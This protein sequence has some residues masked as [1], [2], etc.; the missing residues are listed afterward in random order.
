MLVAGPAAADLL[1]ACFGTTWTADGSCTVAPGETVVYY[2]RGADGGRGGDGGQG[3]TGGLGWTGKATSPGGAGRVGGFGAAPGAGA[4]IIGTFTNATSA[5]IVLDLVVGEA[6]R[7]GQPGAIGAAGDDAPEDPLGFPGFTGG[8]GGTGG[9]GST[10]GSSSIAVAGTP[11]VIAGGGT[12]GTGGTGG[13]GG[14]GGGA[15]GSTG[16]S[17]APGNPGVSGTSGES[18]SLLPA[19]ALFSVTPGPARIVFPVDA[20]PDDPRR[21]STVAGGLPWLRS[22]GRAASDDCP[23]GWGASWQAWAQSVTGGWVC[24]RTLPATG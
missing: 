22:V 12:G 15:D 9:A 1:P 2:V 16:I 11:F 20:G 13:Q 14:Q 21:R 6:A 8:T 17:G 10:G 23:E 3:G 4:L 5:G 24:T 18:T 19:G 7:D